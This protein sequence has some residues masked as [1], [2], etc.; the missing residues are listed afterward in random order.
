MA[1]FL[2]EHG[3]DGDDGSG[4]ARKSSDSYQAGFVPQNTRRHFAVKPRSGKSGPGTLEDAHGPQ[5][6]F[7]NPTGPRFGGPPPLNHGPRGSGRPSENVYKTVVAQVSNLPPATDERR[8]EELFADYPS[9]KVVKIDRIPPSGPTTRGR[10]SL[11]MKVTFADDAEPRELDD[12]MNKM[13]DK[14]YLGRGYYLHLDRFL[15]GT[16]Q[17][18]RA[19]Q[20]VRR[21]HGPHRAVKGLCPSTRARKRRATSGSP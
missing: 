15:G 16:H 14:K 18:S 11:T 20:T 9:L 21:P 5:S 13:N 4:D 19:E 10:P 17:N 2:D 6:R 7:G 1:D 8:V 12:A 3:D